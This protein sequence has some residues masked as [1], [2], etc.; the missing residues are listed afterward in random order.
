M[1][2]KE[3]PTSSG[4]SQN[5]FLVITAL[6]IVTTLARNSDIA[7]DMQPDSKTVH[8]IQMLYSSPVM[9]QILAVIQAAVTEFFYDYFG[10]GRRRDIAT[11]SQTG[12]TADLMQEHANQFVG[13]VRLGA[14]SST[15][16]S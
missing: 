10:V 2:E 9:L 13:D 12:F 14:A 11:S 15:F 1:G 3:L 5:V 6:F 16:Q 4:Q 8:A 7:W